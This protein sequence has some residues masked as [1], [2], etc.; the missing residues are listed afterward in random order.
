MERVQIYHKKDSDTVLVAF[1]DGAISGTIEISAEQAD[2]IGDVGRM[3]LASKEEK[4]LAAEE[5]H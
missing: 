1:F 5:A 4:K 3:A 2:S